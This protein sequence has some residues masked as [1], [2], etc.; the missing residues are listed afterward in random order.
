MS[1]KNTYV[2]KCILHRLLHDTKYRLPYESAM[3]SE[4]I[5]QPFNFYPD[6][7]VIEG[8]SQKYIENELRWYRS[9]DL[10]IKD[11]PGIGTNPIWQNCATENGHINSN[12]G[13]CVY[14]EENYDQFDNA[15]RA[16]LTDAASR[17][18]LIIYTRP[19]I[20]IEQCDGIH[21]NQDM[22][23]TCYT[24]FLIRKNKL[25]MTV[26]M[27]SN[28]A[29]YGL[30]YDL[31]WQLNVYKMMYN[32]LLDKYTTLKKGKIIWVAD[33]LHLYKNVKDKV[34]AWYNEIIE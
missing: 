23:C 7:G 5:C 25:Y 2:Y 30:R 11:W 3:Y 21:A 4:I 26:H 34:E 16:L 12:Y 18:A 10:S 1:N 9:R 17:R 6:G 31:V 24:D 14:D 29:W 32:R 13:W 8:S 15:L 28:D 22:L 27:R 33:S 19:S 20:H